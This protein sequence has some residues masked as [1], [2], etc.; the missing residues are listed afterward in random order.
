MQSNQDVSFKDV[1]NTHVKQLI[2][3]GDALSPTL[4]KDRLVS[5]NFNN[6]EGSNFM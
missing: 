3:E 6:L 2:S 1:M 5:A 4:S